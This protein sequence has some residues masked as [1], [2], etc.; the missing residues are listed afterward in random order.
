MKQTTKESLG[1]LAFGVMLAVMIWA[2]IYKPTV[3]MEFEDVK[4]PVT[5][6]ADNG[7]AL[8]EH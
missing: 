3:R 8:R 2:I 5:V 7:E 4:N 1:A 6:G